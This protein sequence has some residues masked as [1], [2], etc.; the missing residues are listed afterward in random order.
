M[1]LA[2]ANEMRHKRLADELD[3][4]SPVPFNG[5]PVLSKPVI[6]ATPRR[7]GELYR[8]GSTD[9][10][11]IARAWFETTP[12]T[13][14]GIP[15]G[16]GMDPI[17]LV[18]GSRVLAKCSVIWDIAGTTFQWRVDESTVETRNVTYKTGRYG[19]LA[20]VAMVL[21]PGADYPVDRVAPPSSLDPDGADMVQPD[22]RYYLLGT[23]QADGSV[24]TQDRGHFAPAETYDIRQS[25]A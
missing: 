7:P 9:T 25:V 17:R 3:G 21:T 16:E 2:T 8:L 23:V 4:D 11:R 18:P 15:V 1:S 19:G 10:Y 5:V 13:Y 6:Q 24:A 12:L 14:G 22:H 20:A